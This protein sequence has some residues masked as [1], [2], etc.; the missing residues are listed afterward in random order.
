MLEFHLRD[1]RFAC[2]GVF[3]P[4]TV[5]TWCRRGVPG[6]HSI[7]VLKRVRGKAG[8]D[9]ELC[10]G[11]GFAQSCRKWM[12]LDVEGSASALQPHALCSRACC[13]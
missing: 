5:K 6:G 8:I 10:D 12:K 2:L 11:R 13:S 4:S 7:A 9:V 1:P 3:H